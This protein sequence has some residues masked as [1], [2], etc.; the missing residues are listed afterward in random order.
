MKQF[1]AEMKCKQKVLY[2]HAL[3]YKTIQITTK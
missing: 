2:E 3:V 1:K